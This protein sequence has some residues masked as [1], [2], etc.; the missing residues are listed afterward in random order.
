MR[1][2]AGAAAPWPAH[3]HAAAPTALLLVPASR[4]PSQTHRPALQLLASK[5]SLSSLKL[6]L[7]PALCRYQLQRPLDAAPP[8][9][10]ASAAPPAAPPSSA[11]RAGAE[12]GGDGG[13]AAEEDDL[14][15][16]D[17]MRLVHGARADGQGPLAGQVAVYTAPDGKFCGRVNTLQAYGDINREVRG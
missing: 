15:G 3:T 14:P 16:A 2:A 8:P 5:P 13:A 17:Y 7:I 11:A 1:R 4:F 10:A 9:P 6:D 12:G